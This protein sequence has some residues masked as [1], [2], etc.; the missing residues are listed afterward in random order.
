MREVLPSSA[1]GL[2]WIEVTDL[3]KFIAILTLSSH[4]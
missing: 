1:T 4:K 2:L 3:T